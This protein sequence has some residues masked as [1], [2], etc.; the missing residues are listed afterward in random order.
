MD[1]TGKNIE[2]AGWIFDHSKG[3]SV[4][5]IQFATSV[6]SWD[7]GIYPISA[8]IYQRKEKLEKECRENE[9]RSKIEIQKG[10][11]G[12]C[13]SSDLHFSTVTG[14]A[15]YFTSDLVE[16]LNEKKKDWVFQGKGNQKIK[17]KGRWTTLDSISLSYENAETLSISG[18]LY[19]VWNIEGRIRGIGTVKIVISEGINGRR[20]SQQTEGTERSKR[21]WKPICIDG[22]SRLYTG[23]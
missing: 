21:Y 1:K 11:I 2:G 17:I 12:E 8:I 23:I 6:L 4:W 10:I 9:Y 3:R 15:L 16:F 13:I 22:V 14:D 20:Y 5:G 7:Y 18:N 19:N